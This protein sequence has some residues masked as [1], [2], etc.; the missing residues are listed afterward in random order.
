VIVEAAAGG[1]ALVSVRRRGGVD[2][3]LVPA[4]GVP[5]ALDD[6]NG[7]GD[8]APGAVGLFAG[9]PASQP[10]AEGHAILSAWGPEHL[11]AGTPAPRRDGRVYPADEVAEAI[12]DLPFVAG[13]LAL[14]VASGGAAPR[15]LFVLLVFTG[16]EKAADAARQEPA[17][18]AE[19]E[20]RIG[21]RLGQGALP[22]RV[23]FFPL[24]PRLAK[25]LLDTTWC[26]TQYRTGLLGRKARSPV[27][28]ALSALRKRTVVD[29]KPVTMGEGA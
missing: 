14:P 4:P 16:A 13:A 9:K 25:G 28:A 8:P 10:A 1:A 26:E 19:I 7:S 21:V 18:R 15:A 20:R 17:R 11:Y 29:P 24:Y 3:R 12:A 6:L 22:D 27:M 2:Q 5:W 23:L